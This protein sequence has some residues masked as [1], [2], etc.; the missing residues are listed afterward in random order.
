MLKVNY[1][2]KLVGLYRNPPTD[3]WYS[4]KQFH[5]KLTK[6]NSI[7]EVIDQEKIFIRICVGNAAVLF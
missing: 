4:T 7:E 6:N 5:R 1:N 2:K 3:L